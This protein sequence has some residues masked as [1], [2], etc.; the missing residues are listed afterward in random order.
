VSN[1]AQVLIVNGMNN[2]LGVLSHGRYIPLPRTP[3]LRNLF[4]EVVW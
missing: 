3:L 2:G 1:D 4:T